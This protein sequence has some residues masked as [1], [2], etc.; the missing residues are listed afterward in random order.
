MMCHSGATAEKFYV[1]DLNFD[2]AF[3]SRNDTEE[4]MSKNAKQSFTLCLSR[5]DVED[6]GSEGTTEVNLAGQKRGRPH[7]ES[8]SDHEEML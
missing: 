1:A 3:Q 8:H 7:S 5:D 2:E 4:A 6:G